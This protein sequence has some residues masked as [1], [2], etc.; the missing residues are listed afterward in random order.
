MCVSLWTI[1][2][3]EPSTRPALGW[4]LVQTPSAR[5]ALLFS[6]YIYNLIRDRRVLW[7]KWPKA[8]QIPSVFKFPLPVIGCFGCHGLGHTHGLE[9]SGVEVRRIACFFLQIK[10]GHSLIQSVTHEPRIVIELP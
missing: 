9:V 1:R 8:A 7:I 10:H 3:L 4:L 6:A 2:P 5:I